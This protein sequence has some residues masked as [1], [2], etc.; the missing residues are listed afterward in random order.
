[1]LYEFTNKYNYEMLRFNMYIG[2]NNIFH[3][4]CVKQTPSR[5]VFQPEIKT[6]LFYATNNLKQIDFNIANKFI[7]REALIRTLNLLNKE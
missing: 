6:F 5:P 7:K 1:M 4:N 2:Q 3:S